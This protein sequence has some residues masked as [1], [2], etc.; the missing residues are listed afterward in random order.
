[1]LA[2]EGDRNAQSL[3]QLDRLKN[4]RQRRSPVRH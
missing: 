1:M 3:H 2:G 4:L